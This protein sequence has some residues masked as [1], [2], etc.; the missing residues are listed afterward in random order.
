MSIV[1]EE[2]GSIIVEVISLNR[3]T[4]TQAEAFRQILFQ[5]IETGWRKIIIDLTDCEFIDSSFLGSMVIALKK[6]KN[7][8]GNLRL[9]GV[10]PDVMNMFRLT[11]VDG[12][13][14]IYETK[15]DAL[16]SYM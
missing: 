8:G 13:F 7:L 10:Q 9:V 1:Q 2:H 12:I 4:L 15:E 14:D 6:V 11:R 5:D 16:E 3:A